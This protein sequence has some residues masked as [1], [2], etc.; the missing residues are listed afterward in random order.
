MLPPAK[1]VRR[2][3]LM[4]GG[5][6]DDRMHLDLPRGPSSSPTLAHSLDIDMLLSLFLSCDSGECWGVRNFERNNMLMVMM[7]K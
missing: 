1:Q 6:L 7:R 2:P 5:N 3:A 4:P